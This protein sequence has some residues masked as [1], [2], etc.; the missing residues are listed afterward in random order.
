MSK[1]KYYAVK[2]GKTP[3]IYFTWADC[4]AQVT[5]YKGAKYKSFP[6][7]EEAMDF[8]GD[9][10]SAVIKKE[11][12]VKETSS[13]KKKT[14]TN[15]K[16]LKEGYNVKPIRSTAKVKT[17]KS[18][19]NPEEIIND[20][21]FIAFVDGSYDRG[22]QIFGSGVIVLDPNNNS[23]D[24]YYNAGYDKWD[25][26]NIVGELESVKVAINKAKELG[27][28]NIAIYHDLKNIALWASGEWQAKNEYTQEYVRYMEKMSEELNICFVKV[29]AH[30]NESVYNDLAD[31]AAK[32]AIIKYLNENK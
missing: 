28:Q 26:W 12:T 30:S 21:E 13:I 27:K 16:E 23:H 10:N 19:I 7:I 11:E 4:S 5:G 25:Q 29:K 2:V 3:G 1:K 32:G 15:T 31:E 17:Y 9:T 6:T 22:N 14:T 20:Y 24:T 8:I 18:Y